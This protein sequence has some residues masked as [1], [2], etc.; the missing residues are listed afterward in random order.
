M[1]IFK[2]KLKGVLKIKLKDHKD[3]R[4]RYLELFNKKLFKKIG[5]KIQFIQ[6]DISV[7]KKNVLRGIH[8]DHKTWKLVTCLDGRFLLLVVNNKK[9]DNEYKKYQFFYLSDKNNI[10]IL[11]PPGFGNSHY[12]LSKK[13]IFYYKQS[14]FYD[15]KSQFTIKWYDK[16]FNFKWPIK[17]KPI[18]SKR[19]R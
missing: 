8:G 3:K 10:Q 16:E 2:T 11:I 14:T 1:I 12:V 15:R 5:Q 17:F 13:T 9:K 18:T 6:D 4:G 19:D 7:S